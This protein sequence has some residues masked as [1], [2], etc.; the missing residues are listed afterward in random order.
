MTKSKKNNQ[1]KSKIDEISPLMVSEASNKTHASLASGSNDSPI[2][3]NISSTINR[4]DKYKNIE[5][6]LIPF[7]YSSGIKN[8]SNMDIRDAVI[9]CQKAY[10]N[11]AI[12]RNTIDLMTEFSSSDIYFQGGSQKS[13]DFFDAL[14]KKINIWDLQDKFFREYYRSGNVFLYRFDTL[15]KSEDV[16]KITQTFGLLSKASAV[17][18][19]ARYIVLN[20]ADI[21]I[22]GGIN[23]SLGRYYKVLSDYELERLKAPKTDEDL[24]VLKGLPPETQKMIK[25]KTLGILNIPLE[26]ERLA[27]VFYKKQDYEPFAVPMGFP[28]LDDINWKSEMK[29][30]DMSITRTMQ[31]AILLVTMGAEPDKGG[32]NQKNLEAMQKLFENQSVGRVLIADYTTKAEFV[33]PD[34]GSI[35]GPA[36]YEVVD[37]DIQIGLNNILIGSEKFANTSI[38]VQVFIERLKQARQAFINEFLIPEIRRISKDLGFKNFPHPNFE[39]IDLKDDI[40]Y[41]RVYS[42]LIELGILTPEEGI[43]AI[44]T[45]RLPDAEESA[46][47][48]IKFKNLKDKGLYQ[49]IIGGAKTQEAGRPSGTTGIPQQTKDVKPIGKGKQSKAESFSLSK[50]KSNLISAQKLEEEICSSLRKKHNLKKMSNEQKDIADQ[51]SKIIISNETPENWIE[52]V[53]KYIEKPHDT[54]KNMVSNVLDISDEHQVDAYLASILYHSKI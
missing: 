12:F 43:R 27:A 17:N 36:K 32:V 14:F 1:K 28:V 18:L 8:S 33:I 29:K 16:N 45:G 44:E 50:I 13:R 19:P 5:D 31:Q 47:S 30:M 39:D 4:T 53:A 10:Y 46:E 2:R 41:S 22:G 9:L 15:V 35:L 42:R 25:Q 37:R 20:P 51:I 49:P 52:S 6:G 38:K 48:Q 3:R 23:F 26:R 40:Q 34:I 21:Q 54:N 11:F 24:E 7:K